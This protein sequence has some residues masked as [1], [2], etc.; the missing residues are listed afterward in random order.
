[1]KNWI[2]F[3]IAVV[4]AALVWWYYKKSTKEDSPAPAAN[5]SAPKNGYTRSELGKKLPDAYKEGPTLVKQ[6]NSSLLN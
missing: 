4:I 6:D 1:M 5:K 3:I 2:Y